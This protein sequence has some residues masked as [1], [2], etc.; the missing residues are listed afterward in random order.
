MFQIPTPAITDGQQQYTSSKYLLQ[1]KS[2]LFIFI[3][4]A[5]DRLVNRGANVVHR[6]AH[7]HGH[8][9]PEPVDEIT[10]N[11]TLKKSDSNECLTGRHILYIKK[12]FFF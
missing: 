9:Q 8:T 3:N 10:N 6:L 1:L 12:F 5:L 4:L 11:R 7:K 2:I